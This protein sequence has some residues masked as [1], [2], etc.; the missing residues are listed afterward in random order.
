MH[1]PIYPV[2]EI[3]AVNHFRLTA[4]RMLYES[5]FIAYV[6]CGRSKGI[7]IESWQ[8]LLSTYQ[9]RMTSLY[10][11]HTCIYTKKLLCTYILLSFS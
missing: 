5:V 7:L 9:V 10:H 6:G 2:C 3:G 8:V 1:R 4:S 11:I